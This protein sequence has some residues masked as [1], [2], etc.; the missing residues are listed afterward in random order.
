MSLPYFDQAPLY[1]MYNSAMWARSTTGGNN[2]GSGT[3]NGNNFVNSQQL[4]AMKC[5]SHPN[6]TS[7]L[8]Q[9]WNGFAKGNYAACVGSGYAQLLSAFTSNQ[10]GAF[11]DVGQYGA[12]FRDMTD[13]V[14]NCVILSEIMNYD[15]G[16]DD[17]GAWAWAS[18][19][20]F[21]GL[22]AS[23][24]ILTPN[25]KNDHDASSY[26]INDTTN[27]VFNLRNDPD[28]TGSSV[29]GA[30]SYHVGGVQAV[31]GDGSVRF[32]SDNINSTTWSNLLSIKDGN[33]LGNF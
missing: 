1:N 8:N 24:N 23:G 7:F 15:N 18:G 31:M 21:N 9:D 22:A 6:V 3:F 27:V 19:C 10:R 14:S 4:P 17:R 12:N 30:R 28:R 33:P 29:T 32:I 25:S 26:A 5:P 20:V 11:S 13:G 16:G 2:T